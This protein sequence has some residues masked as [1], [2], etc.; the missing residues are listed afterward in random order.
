MTAVRS[1]SWGRAR[2]LALSAEMLLSLSHAEEA[3]RART[4]S[5]Q[6]GTKTVPSAR[7]RKEGIRAGTGRGMGPYMKLLGGPGPHANIL[8]VWLARLFSGASVECA[9]TLPPQP[10][11]IYMYVCML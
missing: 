9:R 1:H 4:P 10:A 8:A 7:I 11:H 2:D 5:L 6:E 3:Y